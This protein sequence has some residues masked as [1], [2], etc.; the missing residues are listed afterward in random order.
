MKK[1]VFIISM[2]IISFI[3]T[4]CSKTPVPTVKEGRFNFS[5]TYEVDGV[6][7]TVSSVF[8]CKYVKVVKTLEGGYREWDS[9]I[10]DSALSAR[11]EKTRGYLLLKT[12]NDGEIFLNLDLSAEY[13]MADPDFI[14]L[15][16]NTDEPSKTISP[17]V[18]IEYTSAKY[19]EIAESYSRDVTVLEN[20]GVKII[21]FEYDPPIENT[22]K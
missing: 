15:N 19:E 6:Q 21:S 18:F 16:E 20:Y 5:V 4:G 14:D 9:Y 10:E 13:F 1:F 11:L 22:Y 12:I 7:E 8:V 17:Y 3:L 2:L